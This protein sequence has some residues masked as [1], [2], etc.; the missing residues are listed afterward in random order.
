M[1]ALGMAQ[2]TGK[3][4]AWLRAEGQPVSEGEPILEIETDKATVEIEASASGVLGGISARAGDEVPVG[5]IIAWILAPGERPPGSGAATQNTSK[6]APTDEG[7]RPVPIS[8]VARRMAQ[9]HRLDLSELKKDGDR[10][11]KADVQQLIARGSPDRQVARLAPASPKAR[12]LARELEI[13]ITELSGS[14]PEGAVL[15]ADV[16]AAAARSS[17][18]RAAVPTM[19]ASSMAEIGTVWKLMAER[20]TQSW[21]SVPHFY[22]LREVNA[23]RLQVW[24]ERIQSKAA[25]HVTISDLLVRLAA[26]ALNQHP[27]MNATWEENQIRVFEE[28]NIGLAVAVEEGLVVPVI[29]Q[30]DR[31]TVEGIA[32]A[33]QALVERAQSRKLS[34]EDIQSGTFTI[35]NLG[36]YGVDA[37]SAIVNSP[38]AAILA[39]GRIAER[40]VPLDG[41]PAIQ[42]MMVVSLSCDHRVVDGAR[43]AQFLQTFVN[44]LE[45]PLGLLE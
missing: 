40:V 4:I 42:P 41:K 7:S 3:V 22:L 44:L 14:G 36:M 34:L 31:L 25:V 35:T 27:R 15:V 30:A 39:V 13:E 24:R 8:P 11:T 12:R 1:P 16:T 37:F 18:A 20:V 38:Q 21:S 29:R 32:A 19:P 10:V 5:E 26:A 9:E 45:E 43:A 6:T 23:S 33:R 2:E 28:I 17:Q